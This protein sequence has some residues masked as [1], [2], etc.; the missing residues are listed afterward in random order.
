M[1]SAAT[2]V[3]TF[4]PRPVLNRYHHIMPSSEHEGATTACVPPTDHQARTARL[5]KPK[6]F[7]SKP[8][9][10]TAI[11]SS[12]R[13]DL[14]NKSTV[15]STSSSPIFSFDC[16][17][18]H[19][20]AHQD[21][22]AAYGQLP[23]EA[24]LNCC[25]DGEAKRDL[26]ALVGQFIPAQQAL[27]LESVVIMTGNHKITSGSEE[28]LVFWCNKILARRT[29]SDSKVHWLDEEQFDEVYWP[30]CYQALT[31]VPR[32]FQLFASKQ[33]LG[34][35]G[36]DV[37]EAYYTPGH[38]PLCLSCGVV[39][40]TCGHILACDEA[41]RV[42]VLHQSIDLL[43]KW[44]KE[45]GTEHNLCRFLVMYARGRGG[46]SMQEIVGFR[47]EY[48][49]L[50]ALVDCIGWRR[51]ME[52]MLS[53]ELVELQKYALV[54]AESRL[55]VDNWAKELVIRLLEVTH[56]QWL[57]R[58]VMVH[59]RTAGDLA[60]KRKEEIRRAL[61]DHLELGEEGLEEDDRF[62]LEINLDARDA[63]ALCLSQAS[64]PNGS[65]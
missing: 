12:H 32:M 6:P 10:F 33:M 7:S 3:P 62:L 56:G 42:E 47:Q 5:P 40:E 28:S 54:E 1:L 45:N 31:E 36:C 24:Q 64:G 39:P 14:N 35:A 34:I 8:C 9:A 60:T 53:R 63:R 16:I 65:H 19:I 58:N 25:M 27:P 20:E 50:A 11:H 21:D 43:D 49:R 46:R 15:T 48:H 29:L 52:G 51:F 44:L 22:Y 59:D 18:E 61:E 17:Y 41:G 38:D 13:V 55:T 2:N 4:Y 30:A 26:W 23:R 57:Y 37:N